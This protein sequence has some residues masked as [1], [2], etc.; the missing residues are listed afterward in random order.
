MAGRGHIRP[1]YFAALFLALLFVFAVYNYG[2]IKAAF[3]IHRVKNEIAPQ[4]ADAKLDWGAPVYL[5]IYKEEK[6]LEL[7]LQDGEKFR[8]FA[9]YPVC[10]L[11]GHLGPKL[12][13]GDRQSPEGFYSVTDDRLNPRSSYHLS[14]YLD[15]PNEYDRA[16]GRDGSFIMVHGN[17]VSVGCYAITDV[18][19]EK[20]YALTQAAF[21]SGQP[22][23]SVH[24]FPFMMSDANMAKYKDSEWIEFWREL[25]PIYDSFE[26]T[27]LV[28]A[29]MVRDKK[30][31][32]TDG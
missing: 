31:Q 29:I 22:A 8:L 19:I 12:A 3:I 32:V 11:S 25:K 15:F 24:I 27:R 16:N 4:L 6:Q 23:V 13:E 18:N 10:D 17:C 7:W 21:D 1:I 30:F 14:L 2:H 26:K 20:V 5:R 28:P 9:T